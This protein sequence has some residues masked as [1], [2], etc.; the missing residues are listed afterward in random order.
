MAILSL[1]LRL[2]VFIG[3][4]RFLMP[5]MVSYWQL[6]VFIGHY[7]FSLVIIGFK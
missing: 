2:W 7:V 6:C 4:F 1:Y 5:I 3:V